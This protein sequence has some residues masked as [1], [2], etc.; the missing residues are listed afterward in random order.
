MP[1]IAF[2]FDGAGAAAPQMGRDLYSKVLPVRDS[3]DRADKIFAA[4]NF[5]VTKACFLGSAEDLSRPSIAAP[6]MLSIAY[7]ISVLL[8]QKRVLPQMLC[9]YGD[10]EWIALCCL[11]ALPYEETLRFL[12]RRGQLIED[13]VAKEPYVTAII[14]GA[15]VE[16]LRK[17]FEKLPKAPEY[18]ADDAPGSC[19]I[20]GPEEWMKKILPLLNKQGLRASPA[21]PG[22]SWP[23]PSLR[24]LA[25]KLAKEVGTIKLERNGAW[26]YYSSLTGQKV[27]EWSGLLGHLIEG[28]GESLRWQELV[29]AMRQAGM[30]TLVEIGPSEALGLHTR[31]IDS[32]IRALSCFDSKSLS[33][34]VKLAL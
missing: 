30:D 16:E 14:Q 9:G 22:A 25:G 31:K 12:R 4:E 19:V 26:D 23:H 2:A 5:K 32:G 18:L 3:M 11:G 1:V 8:K 10:G 15:G 28:L 6:A 34:A 21:L 24:A 27:I 17:I 7:G 13:A 20:A 29:R 33:A